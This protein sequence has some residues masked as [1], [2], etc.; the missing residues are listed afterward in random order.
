MPLYPG[1]GAADETGARNT[2]VDAPLRAGDGGAEFREAMEVAI[3]PGSR[4]SD[5]I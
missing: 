5:R 2:V 3:L 1:T 4:R